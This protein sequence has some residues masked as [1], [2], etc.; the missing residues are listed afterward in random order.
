MENQLSTTLNDT[1][2]YIVI[3]LG[4]EQYGIDI[5]YIDNI[6]RMQQITRVPQ[7]S[8]YWKG[9]INLRGEVIPVMSLR[10]KMGMEA[11]EATKNTRI[12]IIKMDQHEPIGV[13]VDSVKEVVTLSTSQ[14]ERVPQDS[15][16]NGYVCGIGKQEQG[17]ISL[18]DIELVLQ[19]M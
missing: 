11:D 15:R 5:K 9:V 17:L 10:V 12:I 7:V 3:N 1:T 19:D 4:T 18:L 16:E 2:Q 6:V 14:V 13:M 8:P